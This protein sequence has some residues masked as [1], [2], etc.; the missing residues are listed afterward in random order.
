MFMILQVNEVK[1]RQQGFNIMISHRISPTYLIFFLV[2][3][4]DLFSTRA[5]ALSQTSG[6]AGIYFDGSGSMKGY[7]DSGSIIDINSKVYDAFASFHLTPTSQVFVTQQNGTTLQPIETFIANPSWGSQTR[8]DEAFSRAGADDVIA[9]ITDNVQDAGEMAASSTRSFYELFESREV[10]TVLLCSLK[11]QFNGLLYFYQQRFPD[12][13]QLALK[14]REE[15]G[16]CTFTALDSRNQRY[17]ILNMVGMRALALYVIVRPTF[18]PD[19][20][21]SLMER[22]EKAL[23]IDHILMVKPADQRKFTLKGVTAKSVVKHSFEAMSRLCQEYGKSG[24]PL[25]APNL[26]LFPPVSP[27]F[28]PAPAF[29]ENRFIL[30]PLDYKPY[31]VDQEMRFG[32]Y[33]KLVNSSDTIVLGKDENG[34]AGNVTIELKDIDYSLHPQFR[35]CFTEPLKGAEGAIIPGFIPNVVVN[36]TEGSEGDYFPFITHV[37]FRFPPYTLNPTVKNI[38]KLA[39]ASEIPLRIRGAICISVPP[40]HFSLTRKYA[41]EHFTHSIYNQGLIYTPED[42]VSYTNTQPTEIVFDFVSTDLILL[43]PAWIRYALYAFIGLLFVLLIF[44]LVSFSRHYYLKF[45]DTGETLSVFLPLPFSRRFYFRDGKEMLQFSRGLLAYRV[46]A[47][48]DFCLE[49]S[50]AQ[51]VRYIRLGSSWDFTVKPSGEQEG[52]IVAKTTGTDHVNNEETLKA[53]LRWRPKKEKEKE[54]EAVADSDDASRKDEANKK[55]V[56]ADGTELGRLFGSDE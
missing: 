53:K 9:F 43:P 46:A 55:S 36:S 40:E 24:F 30:R 3:I 10:E 52:V 37:G 51:V 18:S 21:P 31:R 42:I 41:A 6:R 5:Q 56:A 38:L 45:N 27:L 35:K 7:F 28:R 39:F 20:I 25:P 44:V 23:G 4:F 11:V 22:L 12:R 47:G 26:E 1:G 54:A 34:C 14:L 13:S 19:S 32:C 49:D 33:I 15:N 50:S 17:H 2:V 48:E 29:D 16:E 8:L